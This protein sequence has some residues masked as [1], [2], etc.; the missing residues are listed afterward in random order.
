[1]PVPYGNMLHIPP[2]N[3]H[4]LAAEQDPQ[5]GTETQKLKTHLLRLQSSNVLP[6]K[7]AAGPYMAM[8]AAPTARDFF[9]ANFYPSGPFTCI[10]SQNLSRVFPLLSVANTGSCV[11]SQNKIGHPAHRYKQLV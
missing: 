5:L 4:L 3:Y 2:T 9:L 10:L 11:G 7:P 6:F 1:M 8:Y